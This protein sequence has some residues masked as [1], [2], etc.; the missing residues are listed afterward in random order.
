MIGLSYVKIDAL[1]FEKISNYCSQNPSDNIIFEKSKN[2]FEYTNTPFSNSM[3]SLPFRYFILKLFDNAIIKLEEV[4]GYPEIQNSN[5]VKIP[6]DMW[7]SIL[8]SHY[9]DM[10]KINGKLNKELK[11]T[12]ENAYKIPTYGFEFKNYL[13]NGKDLAKYL[14]YLK[15]NESFS[16]RKGYEDIK[17]CFKSI[18]NQ[19]IDFD[20]VSR[21]GYPE[22]VINHSNS[23]Q[24]P[25]DRVGSGI[26]EVLNILSVIIGA[27]EKVILL[28]EPALHLHPK[29]QKKLLNV[30][31]SLNK[32]DGKEGKNNQ[33]IIIT[34]SPYLVDTNLLSNTFRFYKNDDGK[35]QVINIYDEF[36]K[37]NGNSKDLKDFLKDDVLVRSLF[38]NGVIL[39]EGDS[40]YLSVPILL[41]KLGCALEDYN[42]EFI[43]VSGKDNFKKYVGLMNALKIPCAVIC[44]GDTAFSNGNNIIKVYK[45]IHPFWIEN[46]IIDE[47]LDNFEDDDFKINMDSR[48]RNELFIYACEEHDWTDFL[49]NKFKDVE[50]N[51]KTL[52]EVMHENY[53]I[54]IEPETQTNTKKIYKIGLNKNG[55]RY[56]IGLNGVDNIPQS[57]MGEFIKYL[58]NSGG[59]YN[60]IDREKTQRINKSNKLGI[61][62]IIS[63]EIPK[64]ALEEM[65]KNNEKLNLKQFV[66]NF[67]NSA[68]Y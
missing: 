61:S 53:G 62:Y 1:S 27:K 46:E 66:E 22:I 3:S 7:A 36:S 19:E 51:G 9:V 31:R 32:K 35:T 26:F 68:T 60:I 2:I 30:F 16:I 5:W 41:R 20:V 28:D 48:L 25:I 13:G 6:I 56:E 64:T 8:S 38:A 4:R 15:N 29:Y 50:I 40:E 23:K 39:A 33:I 59:K 24:L 49:V 10:T 47:I 65:A 52:K 18:F 37:N 57:L 34:H 44:D 43:N 11:K 55:K 63:K 45:D 14:F 12:Y 17:G 67:I 21:E 42:I 58:E 54:D